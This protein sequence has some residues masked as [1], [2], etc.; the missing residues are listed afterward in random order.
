MDI[1]QLSSTPKLIAVNITHEEI[2]KKYG[3]QVTFYIYDRQPLDLYARM[4]SMKQDDMMSIMELMKIVILD[5]Q[6]E[7]VMSEGRVLPIDVL[8]AAMREVIDILGK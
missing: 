4:A 8:T 6:G 1:T 3:E 7:P 2:I 5:A